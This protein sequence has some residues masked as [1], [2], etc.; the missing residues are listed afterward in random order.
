MANANISQTEIGKLGNVHN[1]TR[2]S[3]PWKV[4]LRLKTRTI[5]VEDQSKQHEILPYFGIHNCMGN[6]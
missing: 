4:G 6:L 3:Y 1:S 2:Y 5:E